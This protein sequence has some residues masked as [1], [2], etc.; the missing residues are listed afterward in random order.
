MSV[1]QYKRVSCNQHGERYKFVETKKLS[2]A[3]IACNYDAPS[4]EMLKLVLLSHTLDIPVRYDYDNH[5][6]YI[7]VVS[8]EALEECI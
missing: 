5:T 2:V 1:P 7:K 4:D 6:A 8:Y 3:Q